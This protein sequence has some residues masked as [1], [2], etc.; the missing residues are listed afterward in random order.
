MLTIFLETNQYLVLHKPHGLNV[1]RLHDFTSVEGQVHDYLAGR[2]VRQPYVG[3]VHRLDRPVSGA[4]LVA[5]RKQALK[6][7]QEQFRER[8]VEKIYLALVEHAPAEPTG[9]LRHYLRK[10]Q[11]GKRAQV[12]TRPVPEAAECRLRYRSLGETADGL[13]LLEV[14]LI[15]G[16]FHQIRAQLAAAGAPIWGDAKYGA[17]RIYLPDGIGLHAYRLGFD[18]PLTGERRTVVAP[19]PADTGWQAAVGLLP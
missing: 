6:Q 3:I 8:R 9:E 17:R 14:E 15:G 19:L 7:L 5:K 12:F 13:T 4:L 16:R 2:G 11:L 18:D 10:D 1:E